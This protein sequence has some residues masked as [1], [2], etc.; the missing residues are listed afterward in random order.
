MVNYSIIIPHKNIPDLLQRCLD[1]IPVRND[2]Q[3]IVVDDN[4]DADKVDFDNFP[5]WK[6]ENYE[7]YLTKKGKG[8]GYARN[9]GLQHATGKWVLFA[10][11]DDFF[12]EELKQLMDDE[13]EVDEDLVFFD[14]KNVL[15]D[16]VS[17]EVERRTWY[18]DC[19]LS[20]L[21]GETGSEERL[22]A[23][24]VVPWCKLIKRDLVERHNIRFEE[25]KWGNDV[26]F[27]TMV[28]IKAK[29][30]SVS[31]RK[32]YVLTE[33]RGSLASDFLGTR[34]EL[35]VR[36]AGAIKSDALYRLNGYHKK[37]LSEIVLDSAYEKHGFWWLAWF[38][39]TNISNWQV[40][41]TT[42]SFMKPIIRKKANKHLR[43]G[44]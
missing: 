23:E 6:G 30:I 5:Q 22:R 15:S 1:S 18:R 37:G 9:V 14:Y 43:I 34:E 38:G 7:F 27:S 39:L 28:A 40:F 16:D 2:V 33:R 8:A 4:S 13:V 10:D 44:R 32:V 29:S 36:L 20:Y 3:V 12:T 17:K 11:A 35:C 25:V 26:F 41:R 21:K 19:F 42:S 31:N 24:V